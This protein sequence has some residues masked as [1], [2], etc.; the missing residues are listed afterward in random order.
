MKITNIRHWTEH[1]ELTRP[2]TIAYK[3]IAAVQ[4]HFV[5]IE[6]EDGRLGLGVAAPEIDVTGESL[7]AC[8]RALDTHLEPLLRGQDVRH[9]KALSRRFQEALPSVPAARAAVD[10]ALYDLIAQYLELPLV[11]ML[12]RVHRALPTSITIGIKSAAESL[13]EAQ[14][15]IDRGFRIL[16]VKIG[17]SL[18]EDLERLHKLREK[19]KRR[20]AIRVDA[21]QGYTLDEFKEFVRKTNRLDLEFIEQPLQAKDVAR[22]RLLPEDIRKK[23]AADESLQDAR[24]A[25]DFTHPPRPFGI[26]NIKLMKCGG[27]SSALQIAEI[28]HIA[29]I[30]LMWGCMDVSIVGIAAALHTAL[31]APAT[32]YLDLD[33]SLDLARDLVEGG[34]VLQNG[35]LSLTDKPGLGVELK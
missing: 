4:N 30:D 28:A 23:T 34:F 21:N 1:L 14:E 3:T 6:A 26:Y 7:A 31:S 9:F 8:R 18:D 24:D 17:R 20:V 25:L 13:E 29:G 11:D 16:K 33:G 32:R 27:I 10:M 15:Y 12:G 2:Y 5:R 19:F 22:M 35:E